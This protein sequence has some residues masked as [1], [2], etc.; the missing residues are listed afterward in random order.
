MY[1]NFINCVKTSLLIEGL[2]VSTHLL[3]VTQLTYSYTKYNIASSACL[4]SEW[5]LDCMRTSILAKSSPFIS[6][7]VASFPSFLRS[8]INFSPTQSMNTTASSQWEGTLMARFT[9]SLEVKV[10]EM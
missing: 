2:V 10:G 4:A 1:K 6:N 9:A 7:G 5:N 3:M 8:Q